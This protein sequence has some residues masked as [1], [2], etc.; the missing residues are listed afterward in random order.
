MQAAPAMQGWSRQ[1]RQLKGRANRM[2]YVQKILL[3]GER[4]LYET[5][6]HWI[7]YGRAILTFVLAVGLALASGHPAADLTKWLL[8]AAAAAA[9]L[10]LVLFLA[11]AI[12]RV[13]TEAAVTD[14]RVVFK[15]GIMARHTIEMNRSKVE[16]VDVDQT[17]LGRLFGY[18]TVVLRGTGGTLEP[19]VGIADPLSFRSHITVESVPLAGAAAPSAD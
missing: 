9:L 16:S 8:L 3:P 7:V 17:L 13:S 1:G 12:R 15:T 19:M 6:L 5:G 14:Q 2:S 10:G 18:G 11:A 4:V